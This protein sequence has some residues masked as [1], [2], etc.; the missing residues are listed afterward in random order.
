M[1]EQSPGGDRSGVVVPSLAIPPPVV[2]HQIHVQVV[3]G[4][5]ALAPLQ[6]LHRPFTHEERRSA[7]TQNTVLQSV[8][9]V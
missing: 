4:Y 2:S 3:R 1:K 6:L 9:V 8:F 5:L 7:W